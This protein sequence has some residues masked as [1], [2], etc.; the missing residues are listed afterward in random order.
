MRYV[1]AALLAALGGNDKTTI[2]L[3]PFITFFVFG[4]SK[5]PQGENKL[6]F[7]S[8]VRIG[9]LSALPRGR[10]KVFIKMFIILT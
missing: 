1:A 10:I 3:M 7:F 8:F 9:G 5:T 2:L 4:S 6:N